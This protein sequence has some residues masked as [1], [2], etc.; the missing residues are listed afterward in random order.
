MNLKKWLIIPILAMALVACG[1]NNGGS[2][3]TSSTTTEEN[4]RTD[5]NA[6]LTTPVTDSFKFAQANQ[7]EGK[8]FAGK[9][10]EN[11]DYLGYVSLRSVTDGDTAIFIQEDY[12]DE[13]GA[14]ISIKTRFLGINTPESTA[15]VEPWGKK[16][17]LFTKHILEAAQADADAHST[18]TKKVFNIALINNPKDGNFEEKDSSGGR[19]LAF[20]W[21]RP[22]ITADWRLLNLEICE[23]A[24]SRNQLFDDDKICN[25]RPYFERAEQRNQQ[26]KYRLYG[27]L[28]PDYDYE[29]KSYEYSLWYVINH[30]EEIGISESGSS[31]VQLIITALVVGIQGDNMFVRDVFHDSEQVEKEGVDSPLA[32]LYA[33]AGYNTSLCSLLQN[34]SKAQGLGDTGVGVV[35]RFFCRAT[36][37]SGNV[38]LSDIKYSTTGKKGLKSI[39]EKNFATY[40]NDYV[41]S[42]EY[43]QKGELTFADMIRDASPTEV[44]PTSV[45]NLG[46]YQYQFIS[47]EVVIRK[48]TNK[49]MSDENDDTDLSNEY[50]YKGNANNKAYTVYAYIDNGTDRVLTNLR[51]DDTLFPFIEPATFG[52][53]DPTDLDG[54]NSP[55]GKTFHVTGYVS[56]Y[57]DKYQIMLPNNYASMHYL[58]KVTD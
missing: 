40:A 39:T 14:Y 17:S 46:V 22:T 43:E 49:E 52:T 1:G 15:K 41:W 26:G 19:W 35:V 42:Y 27:E 56:A 6:L 25:Y 24:Y 30:F 54:P 7:L 50:W 4:D 33:Y 28:D 20:I 44:V 51:I 53:S 11:F 16:A 12:K 18:E 29:E 58:Y 31:G 10:G 9:D 45:T 5:V 34:A 55:V 38:Q 2:K 36:Y 21:Y 13:F 47:T 32:G 23:Q 37:Y 3:D 48:I 8:I 57:F